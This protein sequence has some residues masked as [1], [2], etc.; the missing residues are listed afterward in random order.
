MSINTFLL[1]TDT[2]FY[3]SSNDPFIFE[4]VQYLVTAS[5]NFFPDLKNLCMF[6][7]FV[8]DLQIMK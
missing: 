2:V 4:E 5:I 1:P 6:S 3:V 8:V 7:L